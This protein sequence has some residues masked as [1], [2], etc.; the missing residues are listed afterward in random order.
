MVDRDL[1]L[2]WSVG[3]RAI[4]DMARASCVLLF[5]LQRAAR[6]AQRRLTFN[7]CPAVTAGLRIS[8]DRTRLAVDA[9]RSSRLKQNEFGSNG[10]GRLRAESGGG[11]GWVSRGELSPPAGE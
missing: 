11:G 7:S 5:V 2:L 1:R 10:A 9:E 8:G 4:R 6:F 3:G